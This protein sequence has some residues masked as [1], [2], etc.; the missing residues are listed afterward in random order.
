MLKYGYISQQEY[1]EALSQKLEVCE[2]STISTNY[3]M[4]SFVEYSIYDAITQL[5]KVNN[6]KTPRKIAAKWIT[7]YAKRLQHLY[8]IDPKQQRQPKTRYINY[9]N[10]PS[11]ADINDKYSYDGQNRTAAT[12]HSFNLRRQVWL[13][14]TAPAISLQW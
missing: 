10:Y 3:E 8:T 5:L 1:D 13:S 9:S 2:N 7:S 4:L 6:L 14:I 11:M 12:A